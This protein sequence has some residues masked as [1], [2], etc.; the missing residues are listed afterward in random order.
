MVISR[1]QVDSCRGCRCAGAADAG[2]AD[3]AGA[4]VTGWAPVARALSEY[5]DRDQGSGRNGRARLCHV[6][7]RRLQRGD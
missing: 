1:S 6:R 7:R 4:Q 2:G 3:T 5:V